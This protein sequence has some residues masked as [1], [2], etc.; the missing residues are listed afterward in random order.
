MR[1]SNGFDFGFIHGYVWEELDVTGIMSYW[2]H[3]QLD[4]GLNFCEKRPIKGELAEIA[5]DVFTGGRLMHVKNLKGCD[6]IGIDYGMIDRTGFNGPLVGDS[7]VHVETKSKKAASDWI[8]TKR[9]S[10]GLPES[11][12]RLIGKRVLETEYNNPRSSGLIDVRMVNR[13]FDIMFAIDPSQIMIISWE[14]VYRNLHYSNHKILLM[15]PLDE[16]D[17]TYRFD[18]ELILSSSPRTL[19]AE[20]DRVTEEIMQEFVSRGD[21]AR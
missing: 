4:H 12:Q 13:T 18:G 16:I 14:N 3:V 15:I 21:A 10:P 7:R 17:F 20:I 9:D 5:L 2:N 8:V 19:S 6:N 11:A 1:E